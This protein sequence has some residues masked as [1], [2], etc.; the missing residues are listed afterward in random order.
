MKKLWGK[1]GYLPKK[2]SQVEKDNI[3]P[4]LQGSA[5]V[6]HVADNFIPQS[7]QEIIGLLEGEKE[8]QQLASTLFIGLGSQGSLSLV[9]QLITTSQ[10]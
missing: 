5:S 8:K 4:V 7:E 2:E 9:W 6:E 3:K 1:E 10:E